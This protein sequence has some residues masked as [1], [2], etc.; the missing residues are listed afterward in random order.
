LGSTEWLHQHKDNLD[1]WDE[2]LQVT[3]IAEQT[4]RREGIT[5]QSHQ[6]LNENYQEELCELKYERSTLLKDELI[7]FI[8]TQGQSC[9]KGERLLGSS[10]VIESVFGKQKYLE[11]NYAKE[12]FTTL[13]LGIG[14]VVGKISIDTVKDVLQHFPVKMVKKWCKDNLGEREH[15]KKIKAYSGAK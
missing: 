1:K 10:E 7:E 15:S 13:I 12:G 11:R 9:K 3:S 2:L 14:A 4:V 6:I 5:E 8:K